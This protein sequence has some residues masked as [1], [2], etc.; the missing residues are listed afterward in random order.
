MERILEIDRIIRD[1]GGVTKEML[2]SRFEIS[3]K[4]VERD[5]SYM[6]D[7]LA[8]PLEYD[9]FKGLYIYSDENYFLPSISMSEGEVMALALSSE[10][11]NHFSTTEDFQQ[12]RESFGRLAS[13]LP[14]KIQVNLSDLNNR[15]TVISEQP[16]KVNNSVWKVLMEGVKENKAVR[17]QY[18]KPGGDKWEEKTLEPYYLVAYKG[19]WYIVANTL[20]DIRTYALSRMKEAHKTSR[21]FTIPST[22]ILDDY[23]D[24]E[25][26]I[27][28]RKEKYQFTLKFSPHA[29][30]I[31]KE[32][33][34]HKDQN[35][36]E[37]DDGSLILSFPSGQLETIG[38]WVLS[39]GSDVEVLEPD[40]LILMIKKSNENLLLKYK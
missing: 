25:W 10:I 13:Y 36:E 18:K 7:R 28:A 40:E 37:L 16:T 2:V 26:G 24:P 6:R 5:F 30:P 29:A 4:S 23:I 22:F 31:I 9:R 27:Y 35:I 12:L 39:W 21:A 20:K 1:R 11:L 14:E 38:R 15:V 8:A 19:S 33:R 34:W 17:V 32:K 3:E